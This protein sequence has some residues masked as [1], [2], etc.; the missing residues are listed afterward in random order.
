MIKSLI[1]PETP[2]GDHTPGVVDGRPELRKHIAEQIYLLIAQAEIAWRALEI[3]DDHA[4]KY[5]MIKI[6]GHARQA[7]DSTNDLKRVNAPDYGV[8]GGAP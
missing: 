6:A 7:I 4:V 1:H 3:A 5:H 8:Q 2:F